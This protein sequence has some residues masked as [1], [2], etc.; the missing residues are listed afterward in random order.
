MKKTLKFLFILIF[1]LLF[2]TSLFIFFFSRLTHRNFLYFP[3]TFK[4]SLSLP[5]TDSL[6]FL[7]LGA[8]KRNDL[9]EKTTTTDTII[10]GHLD[11]NDSHLH[12]FSLPRDLWDYSLKSKINQIYPTA[13]EASDSAQKFIYITDNFSRITGKKIKKVLVLNTDDLKNLADILGGVDIYLEQGFVDNQYPNESYINNPSPE[14]PIYKTVKFEAGWN[15]LDSTNISEFV[16]SRKSS[17]LAA[18]GGTDLGRIDRQQQLI[19]TLIDRLK[20]EVN[21]NPKIIPGLYNFWQ[22]LEHNFKDTELFSYGLDHFS[23]LPSL[24][25]I[26]HPIPTGENPKSDIIYH[27]P[28]FINRQWVFITQ[29]QD[30]KTLHDFIDS[31]LKNE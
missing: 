29:S 16:R 13:R 3:K 30:F 18:N 26:R 9:L 8:D 22:S 23:T 17:D 5:K 28:Y 20:S 15:H 2:L 4:E 19:N 25:I 21:S 6:D 12:L 31:S 14:I 7:V 27:P 1:S 24:K 10:Y 11:F